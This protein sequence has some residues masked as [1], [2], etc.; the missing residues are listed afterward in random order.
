MQQIQKWGLMV[1]FSIETINYKLKTA[2][3]LK[4]QKLHNFY[5]IA[6]IATNVQLILQQIWAYSILL[7]TPANSTK[8]NLGEWDRYITEIAILI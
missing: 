5:R 7:S 8:I 4:F 2:Q 6:S 1:P 3:S